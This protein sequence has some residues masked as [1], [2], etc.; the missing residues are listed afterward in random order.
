[1]RKVMTWTLASTT[2]VA[3]ACG[4][5]KAPTTAMSDDLKRD[6]K[7]ASV[8]QNI[9]ISPDAKAKASANLKKA[10]VQP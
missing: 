2:L 3:I 6:L 8:T 9:Q 7:L 5:N 1:M 4:R 10:T